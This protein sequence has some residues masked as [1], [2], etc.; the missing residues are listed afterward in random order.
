[1][2]LGKGKR[3]FLRR[4]DPVLAVEHHRVADVDGHD[5]RTGRQMLGL[6][7]LQVFLHEIEVPEGAFEGV[8]H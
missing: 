3:N 6:E 1:M 8:L 7:D 5:S 4:C 2:E